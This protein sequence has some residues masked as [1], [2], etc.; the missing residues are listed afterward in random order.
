[1]RKLILTATG[2]LCL[3]G[4]SYSV[5]C[6]WGWPEKT[7]E[8]ADEAPH[9]V[10]LIDINYV[11]SKYE[12]LKY[13]REDFLASVKEAQAGYVAKQKK[14][15]ELQEE[16]NTFAQDSPEFEARRNRLVK[17]S[18]E[19]ASEKKLMEMEFAKKEAKILHTA[20]LEVQDAVEKF[21]DRY[22]FTV[23]MSFNRSD[24]SSADPRRVSQL[25]SQPIV[26]HRKRDDLS[27]GVLDY[28]NQRYLKAAGGEA[29][30]VS[31]TKAA[32]T[33]PRSAKKDKDVKPAGGT[34]R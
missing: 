11:F 28:L 2:F 25:L 9:R 6:A 17:M 15:Q 1:V 24:V 21:C 8:A 3:A 34:D 31:D 20:Y 14:A 30:P 16:L 12:K 5:N 29:R 23:I 7:K 4:A 18:T 33:A 19:L 27:Q 13:E 10:G 32:P 26:Y 22:R